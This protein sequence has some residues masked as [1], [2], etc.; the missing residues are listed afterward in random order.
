VIDGVRKMFEMFSEVCRS[1]GG[2]IHSVGDIVACILPPGVEIRIWSR[3][4]DTNKVKDI[5]ILLMYRGVSRSIVIE[6]PMLR[7]SI[8]TSSRNTRTSFLADQQK[9]YTVV[10]II[11]QP[12]ILRLG[13][14][15]PEDALDL[16]IMDE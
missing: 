3:M 9:R 16:A 1:V 5:E 10:E 15:Y 12:R 6:P 13:V 4:Y 7:T 8:I 2:S 11:G 14:S